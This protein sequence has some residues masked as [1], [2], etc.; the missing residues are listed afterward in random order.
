MFIIKG[1]TKAVLFVLVLCLIRC[2]APKEEET[3]SAQGDQPV[4]T[5]GVVAYYPFNG[6][7]KDERGGNHGTVFGAVLTADRFGKEN[8]AY[9]FNGMDNYILIP[10]NI[11][12]EEMPEL[13]LV[14][15]AN[16]SESSPIRQVISHDDG[17]F[18]RSLGID[19]RGGGQGWSAFCG[20]GEVL[21][22]QQVTDGKWVF[23]AAVYN[24]IDSTIKLYVDDAVYESRGFCGTG[25]DSTYIG[26]NPS[27]G[28]YF[29]G[30]IDDVIIYN[31]ALSKEE[32]KKLYGK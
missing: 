18:D 24:Q 16:T 28:E 9:E 1:M 26:M 17:G 23:V 2:G 12:P 7:A 30:M 8:S 11:N 32:I 29:A 31:R 15:W 14:A 4:V 6:N 20:S 19:D 10:V 13:T 5:T 25:H 3:V 21:G 27:Y 22:F